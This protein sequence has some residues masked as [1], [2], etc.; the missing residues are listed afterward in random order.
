M[1]GFLD[2]IDGLTRRQFDL[3]VKRLATSLSYGV[4]R[5]PYRGSGLEYIQSRPYQFGDPIRSI[6]WRVTARTGR[7]FVKE[8]EASKRM[9]CYIVVDTSASMTIC[10][11]PRSKYAIAVQLAGGLA[12]AALD[13]ASPVGV[14][15]AGSRDLRIEPSLS[16]MQIHEW[17][18]RLRRYRYDESTT[19][20]RRV[21]ELT[22]LLTARS[23][24]IVLSDLFDPTALAA[25]RVAAQQHECLVIHLQDPAE[26]SLRGSGF[27]RGQEAETGR[28]FV[29]HGRR[30]WTDPAAIA[31][32]LKRSRIDVLPLRTD[33]PIVPPLRQFLKA[34][35][36]FGRQAR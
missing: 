7:V 14:V 28:R 9:P 10:S 26:T 8:Y 21:L 6:D 11:T 31:L 2:N 25:L 16:S 27:Y 23:M 15:G 1:E 35:S 36:L 20:G 33:Q 34:R 13:R 18:Y 4:D 32:A 30:T 3:A 24:L 19:L 12:F 17:V 22:P 29:A 5:S